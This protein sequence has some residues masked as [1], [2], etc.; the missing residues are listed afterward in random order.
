MALAMS[1]NPAV[2]FT[3]PQRGVFFGVTSVSEMLALAAEA[4]TL[5]ERLVAHTREAGVLRADVE[6]NDLSFVFEQ[7]SSLRAATPARTAEIRARYLA[8]QLDA[9]RAPG[10]TPLP[11]PPPADAEMHARWESSSRRRR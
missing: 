6:P 8:L 10:R 7:L 4:F 2:G 5:N 11:G 3:L 1:P 9:L